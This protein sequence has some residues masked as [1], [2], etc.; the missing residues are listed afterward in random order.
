MRMLPWIS[1][2][3]LIKE[4][5][6]LKMVREAMMNDDRSKLTF[7]EFSRVAETLPKHLSSTGCCVFINMISSIPCNLR[8]NK[9]HLNFPVLLSI[10]SNALVM[11]WPNSQII[12]IIPNPYDTKIIMTNSIIESG[13]C[14]WKKKLKRL[15]L[16][17]KKQN[18]RWK[19]H[20]PLNLNR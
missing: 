19:I 3:Q 2:K 16:A 13:S 14:C 6:E 20:N 1:E 12:I 18:E 10:C 15:D 17:I 9:Y 11:R 7:F 8:G 4:K 5:T